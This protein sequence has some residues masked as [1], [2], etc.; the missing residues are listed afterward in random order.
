M[1][2]VVL[3]EKLSTLQKKKPNAR[4]RWDL[5]KLKDPATNEKFSREVKKKIGENAQQRTTTEGWEKLKKAI[6]EVAENTIGEKRRLRNDWFDQ[7][8]EEIIA[9]KND[10]R[11]KLLQRR[12]RTRQEEYDMLRREANKVCR[13]KKK[14]AIN[15]KLEEI[16]IKNKQNEVRNF[17]KDIN[18]FRQDFKP[19]L[20]GCKDKMG[21]LLNEEAAIAA[22]WTEHFQELLNEHQDTGESIVE[23]TY[24]SAE[25]EVTKPSL[26]EVKNA[27]IAMKN[28][29]AAGED[30]IT[31]EML[32]AGKESVAAELHKIVS[33]IWDS[34]ILPEQWKTGIIYPVYK[35][36]D[37][38]NCANYRGITLL[39][40]AYKVFSNILL[41]RVSVY[42][43]EIIGEYQC[44]FR[45]SRG[46]VDQIFIVRQAME[47]CFE[48]K[49][50]LHMLFVDF[51]Q[52]FDS[53]SKMKLVNYM[54]SKGIPKKLVKLIEI[55]LTDARAKVM[56]DGHCGSEFA[57]KRGVRQ[58]DAL[59]A[60]LFNLALQA[61]LE[62]T[63]ENGHIIYKAQ[64]ARTQMTL[65][66]SPGMK[67]S[68]ENSIPKYT[69]KQEKSD[70]KSTRKKQSTW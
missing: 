12:T 51:R 25:L 30:N 68:Y 21:K 58:G 24:Y 29:M 3:K 60:T 36:G 54:Y 41:K 1:V 22:R 19:R 4:K 39:N 32:K 33:T 14:K 46:T 17:Y 45:K 5:E 2:R 56:I 65:C 16:E 57:L 8:C 40:V 27:I 15:K 59:S 13:R 49:T 6:V 23:N 10:A 43:E 38:L 62:N 69:Q 7:E 67:D 48:H 55:T 18:Y 63:A 34:E 52:A 47:K 9:R 66:L 64:C 53:I 28:Y 35:K 61:V 37:K 11:T 20:S 70:L 31:S 50:D 42:T 26:L 44:G